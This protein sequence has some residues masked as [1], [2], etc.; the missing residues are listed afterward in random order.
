[1]QKNLNLSINMI[2]LACLF[3][4]FGPKAEAKYYQNGNSSEPTGSLPLSRENAIRE[5]VFKY[6]TDGMTSALSRRM[7]FSL[8]C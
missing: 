6:Q 3:V 5:A 8:V 1:M 4:L 7:F 2:L